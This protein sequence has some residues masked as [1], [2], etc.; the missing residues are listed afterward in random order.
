MFLI[1]PCPSC[2]RRIR[3]PI[4]K[5]TLRVK[6]RC[7]NVFLADPDDPRLYQGATFDLSAGKRYLNILQRSLIKIAGKLNFNRLYPDIIN[8]FL[9]IKYDMQN[10]RLLPSSRQR[11]I[12]VILIILLVFL[13]VLFYLAL[14]PYPV[15]LPD[16]G[17]IL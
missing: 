15:S 8:F 6:C 12:V 16:D 7:G 1:K 10:F 14:R 3:F 5:G 17:T 13:L 4:D 9:G 11:K 2:G